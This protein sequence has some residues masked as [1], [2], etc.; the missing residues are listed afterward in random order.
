[1]NQT[2]LAHLNR[3]LALAG[4]AVVALLAGCGTPEYRAERAHCE[5]E[6]MLK[7][8]PVY[9]RETVIRERSE[10]RPSGRTECRAEGEATICEPVM[11]TVQVPYTAVETVDLRKAERDPQI[12]SCAARACSLRYGNSS[13]EP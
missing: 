9:A 13:C 8:P 12:A 7:M 5:A 11:Q 6:W 3:H 2:R 10:Q 1:M 4:L